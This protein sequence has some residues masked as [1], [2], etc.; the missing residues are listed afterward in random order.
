MEIKEI[1]IGE[2]CF[3]DNNH[4]IVYINGERKELD[5]EHVAELLK[6]NSSL[7]VYRKSCY[8]IVYFNKEYRK[9]DYQDICKL[10]KEYSK[11]IEHFEKNPILSPCFK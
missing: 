6:E 10:L 11:R 9:M 5:I 7:E 4:R 3:Y 1:M 2:C 8:H